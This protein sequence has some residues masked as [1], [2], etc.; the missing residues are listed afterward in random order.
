[1]ELLPLA[2]V[3]VS[4]WTPWLVCSFCIKIRGAFELNLCLRVIPL[5][6][7]VSIGILVPVAYSYNMDE[8]KKLSIPEM[9]SRAADFENGQYDKSLDIYSQIISI[10]RTEEQAWHEKGR[11]LNHLE[12][13]P[14]SFEHY[15]EYVSQFSDSERANEGYEIAKN[16]NLKEVR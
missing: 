14:E 16:C 11:I 6:A 8:I 1:M 9:Y 3:G 13:C 10:D 7:I 12:R 2:I 5:I 15:V 4:F